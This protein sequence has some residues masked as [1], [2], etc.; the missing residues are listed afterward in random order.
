LSR[1]LNAM[2]VSGGD[3]GGGLVK[4]TIP[5]FLPEI[6]LPGPEKTYV[7]VGKKG[8]GKSKLVMRALAWYLRDKVETV[9]SFVPTSRDNHDPSFYVPEAFDYDEFDAD[10]VMALLQWI[11]DKSQADQKIYTTFF[12]DDCNAETNA[13]GKLYNVYE[14]PAL[15]KLMKQG[16][17]YGGGVVLG[18]QNV[19]DLPPTTRNQMHCGFFFASNNKDEIEKIRSNWC[20]HCP[21]EMFEPVFRS[22]TAQVAGQP[23]RCLVVLTENVDTTNPLGGLYVWCPPMIEK[24]FRCGKQIYYDLSQQFKK[25]IEPKQLNPWQAGG[26]AAPSAATSSGPVKRVVAHKKKKNAELPEI[27]IADP[28]IETILDDTEASFV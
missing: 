5:R 24:P 7:T 19:T 26:K 2:E 15:S 6:H 10:R 3:F 20:A 21:K 27:Y 25:H 9:L 18:A 8:S 11:K 28:L 14:T 22:A 23:R 12:F 13:K 4:H 16:R 17:H 1:T